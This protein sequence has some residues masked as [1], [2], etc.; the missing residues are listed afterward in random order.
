MLKSFLNLS[1]TPI[2]KRLDGDKLSGLICASF[3]LACADDV[4]TY[5]TYEQSI[6]PIVM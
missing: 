6:M 2:R 4:A 3:F 1:D 5:F